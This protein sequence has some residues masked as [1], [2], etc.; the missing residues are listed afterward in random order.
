[1]RSV[2]IFCFSP[3]EGPGFFAEWLRAHRVPVEVIPL[4][5]G[6]GVPADPR[7]YAGIGMMGG[8]MSANDPLPWNAPLT[9][10][11]R[12]AVSAGVPVI[13][14]CLGGQLL[15]RALG[16]RVTRAPRPEIGWLDASVEGTVGAEWFGRTGTCPMFQWH[17]DTFEV[18]SVATRVLSDPHVPNQAYVVDDRHIG[19]QGH[20]EM[21]PEL[22]E[23]WLATGNDELPD[24][25]TANLQSA[26]EIRRDQ[27]A[28]V[29][30][31]HDVAA[32]VYAR[33]AQ[34]LDAPGPHA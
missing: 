5:R 2:A 33:W 24:T 34:G 3:T 32:A 9:A 29:A 7:Q 15:A 4:D 30:A 17:Y 18:P 16:A 22:I 11:L 13:G 19:L 26:A 6:A 25:S 21:T 20:V 8:P 31:L 14:H 12:D 1:M 28:R 23:S 10:L 27:A